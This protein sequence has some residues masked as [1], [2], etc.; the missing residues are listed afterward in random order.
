MALFEHLD[1]HCS[2]SATIGSLAVP[3]EECATTC[4]HMERCKAFTF[5]KSDEQS[6]WLIHT[7]CA[8]TKSLP[9]AQTYNKILGKPLLLKFIIIIIMIIIIIVVV[10]FVVVAAAAVVVVVANPLTGGWGTQRELQSSSRSP[11]A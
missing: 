3:L 11:D 2:G 6:C 9:T 1:G 10:V 5:V 4:L 8:S 7:A